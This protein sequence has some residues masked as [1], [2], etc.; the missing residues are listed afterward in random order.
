MY[1]PLSENDEELA[2]SIVDI[3]FKIH[4]ALGPGM[5]ESVYEQCFC[6]ELKK[7][8]IDFKKQQFIDIV[9]DDELLMQ[10]ALKAD[11]LVGD[12]IIVEL[13]AQEVPHPIWEA[14]LLSYLRLRNL[15]LG[16]LINFHVLLIKNGI[17]RFI[18]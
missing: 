12:R 6:F 16:F 7:R 2:T 13:K 15:R 3:A 8:G 18:L 4:K 14:Q 5:L 1:T 11:I 17:K 9:Y 10:D